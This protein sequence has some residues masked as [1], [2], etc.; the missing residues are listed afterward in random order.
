AALR[1]HPSLIMTSA[2]V[3]S[4]L[5]AFLGLLT[6]CLTLSCSDAAEPLAVLD[7]E[8]IPLNGVYIGFAEPL[9]PE[10]R[11][12]RLVKRFNPSNIPVLGLGKR[13]S[14]DDNDDKWMS[15]APRFHMGFG[16]RAAEGMEYFK[17]IDPTKIQHMGF[18]KRSSWHAV[19]FRR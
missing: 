11:Y 2:T 7:E 9:A 16:K 8:D 6:L 18:G 19:D 14:D 3:S 13:S 10:G 4:L 17:R 1:V 15:N 12:A 5:P